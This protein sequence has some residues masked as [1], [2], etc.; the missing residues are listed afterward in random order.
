MLKKFHLGT[1][2]GILCAI[3]LFAITVLCGWLTLYSYSH[4]E[5]IPAL[6]CALPTVF[7]FCLTIKSVP[8][9]HKA[10]GKEEKTKSKIPTK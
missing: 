10:L 1:V 8:Y 5:T 3:S 7:F 6:L 4:K 9:L 2:C